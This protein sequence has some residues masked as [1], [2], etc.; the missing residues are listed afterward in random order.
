M[1]VR[2]I[3]FCLLKQHLIKFGSIFGLI[4]VVTFTSFLE[5]I[6][7]EYLRAG[8]ISFVP[9]FYKQDF[10]YFVKCCFRRQLIVITD[11]IMTLEKQFGELVTRKCL[12][13]L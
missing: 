8:I 5:I 10:A 1:V 11:D 9:D 6:Q 7:R 2:E 4:C 3:L 13:L 12:R